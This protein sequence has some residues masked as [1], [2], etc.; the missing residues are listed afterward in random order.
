MHK[1]SYGRE[2]GA[3]AVEFAL[4]LPLLVVLVFGIIEFG[5]AFTRSQAMQAAAREGGRVAAI[6]LSAQDVQDA[7]RD[8]V[9]PVGIDS[10]DVAVCIDDGTATVCSNGDFCAEAGDTVRV[11][12]SIRPEATATYGVRIPF[13]PAGNST[14]RAQALF[15]CETEQGG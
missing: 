6:G 5:L 10:G 3:S 9:G 14:F 12:A 15:R 8:A 4:I 11:V 7:V 13:L 1:R 2:H